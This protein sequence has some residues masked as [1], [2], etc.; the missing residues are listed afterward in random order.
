MAGQKVGIVHTRGL[1]ARGWY[2]GG[3]VGTHVGAACDGTAW[4]EVMLMG[5]EWCPE[6]RTQC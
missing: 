1:V 6:G 3:G 5:D 4:M 2:C